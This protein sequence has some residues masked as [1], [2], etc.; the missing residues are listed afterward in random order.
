MCC[1]GQ[2][3][4]RELTYAG[5]FENGETLVYRAALLRE[6]ISALDFILVVCIAV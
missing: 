4:V 6:M 5:V 3:G 1:S 2:V